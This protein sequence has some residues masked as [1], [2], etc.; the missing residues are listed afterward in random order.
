MDKNVRTE[1]IALED[2]AKEDLLEILGAT[3]KDALECNVR[4]IE[5][6]F[7]KL[8]AMLNGKEI[9]IMVVP[10][11]EKD[12]YLTEADKEMDR[13]FEE[14]VAKAI[15]DLKAKNLP[16]ARYDDKL[17]RAYLEMPD[18]TRKELE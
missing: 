9:E 8:R 11:G 10:P 6:T 15:A 12:K 4:P 17:E 13:R 3:H 1:Q 18:G 7:E 2:V 5:D 14:A 16:V